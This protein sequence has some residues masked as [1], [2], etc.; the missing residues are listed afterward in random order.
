MKE[1]TPTIGDWYK[2]PD[3]TLFEIVAIDEEDGTIEIQY[4]DGTL[5]EI[6]AEAWCDTL[7]AAA[8]PPEDYSGSLDIEKED[9]A[10]DYD[11]GSHREWDSALEFLDEKRE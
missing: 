6:D 2:N 11:D 7:I 5:D 10:V 9:Y 8:E 4:Y 1:L 3:G